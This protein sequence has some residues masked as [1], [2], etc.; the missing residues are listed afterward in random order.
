[1]DFLHQQQGDLPELF[2]KW[3]IIIDLNHVWLNECSWAHRFLR[4][5][6]CGT[7]PGVTEQNMPALVAKIP[8]CSNLTSQT[9]FPAFAL[10]SA[11]MS[12]CLR[13]H[14]ICLSFQATSVALAP[15]WQLLLFPQESSSSESEGMPYYFSLWWWHSC[16][17]CT[18]WCKCSVLSDLGAMAPLQHIGHESSHSTSHQWMWSLSVCIIMDKKE[19][20]VLLPLVVT[21]SLYSVESSTL[22]ETLLSSNVA[23]SHQ[24]TKTTCLHATWALTQGVAI[25]SISS[26]ITFMMWPIVEVPKIMKTQATKLDKSGTM[27]AIWSLS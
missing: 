25:A 5:K 7:Q 6:C 13:P 21:T 4:R 18:Y 27:R 16:C 20:I 14:P 24:T 3:G 1:M 17:Q 19:S 22:V 10:Q 11:S 15:N 23:V 8:S 2:L 26:L 12:G 9:A